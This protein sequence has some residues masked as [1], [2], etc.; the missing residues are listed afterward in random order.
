MSD[1]D[2]RADEQCDDTC[3]PAIAWSCWRCAWLSGFDADH[4]SRCGEPAE[5]PMV[6]GGNG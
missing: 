5:E 3:Q 4:C 2:C 1:Y 6:E